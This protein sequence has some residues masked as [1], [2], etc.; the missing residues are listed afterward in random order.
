MIGEKVRAASTP[1]PRPRPSRRVLLGLAGLLLV[2]VGALLVPR[3]FSGESAEPEPAPR[4]ELRRI[5]ESAVTGPDRIAPGA[6]AYVSGPRGTWLGAAGLANAKAGEPMRP[7]ARMRLESVSKIYTAALVLHL[8]QDRKLRLDDTV[9]RWLPGVLPYGA[10]ITIRQL[11]TMRS[12]LIDTSDVGRSPALHLARVGDPKL[13]AR[14]TALAQRLG[15]NPALE[16]SPTWWSGSRPGS[17]SCPG[18]ARR[19]TTR[20]SATSCSA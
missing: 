6:T 3:A 5:V 19:P 14:L 18:P 15:E 8:A 11:L 7:D 13:R 12:G 9:E 20:T 1:L 16:V 10:R 4:P 2:A 17:R